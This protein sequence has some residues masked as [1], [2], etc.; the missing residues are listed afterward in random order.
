MID[1]KRIILDLLLR[2]VKSKNIAEKLGI[3]VRSIYNITSE[4]NSHM[5]YL[6]NS[7]SMNK[8]LSESLYKEFTTPNKEFIPL[9]NALFTI[10]NFIELYMKSNLSE[11]EKE[12]LSLELSSFSWRIEDYSKELKIKKDENE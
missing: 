12:S 10:K 5:K 11:K 1:I 3:N 2:D 6:K 8:E 9:T 7:K 4:N